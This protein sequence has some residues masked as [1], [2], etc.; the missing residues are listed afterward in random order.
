MSWNTVRPILSIGLINYWHMQYIDF[1]LAFLQATVKTDIYMK[2]PKVPK[3]FEITDLLNFTDRLIFGYEIT[4][5]LYGLKYYRKTW[6]DYPSNILINRG[7]RQSSID[8]CLLTK[9][10]VILFIYVKDINLIS[11][12]N[13]KPMK[14]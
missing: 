3:K 7:W 1:V 14:K 9:N 11:P 8:E 10:W 13:K 2:P 12:I 5:N 6:C 4:K